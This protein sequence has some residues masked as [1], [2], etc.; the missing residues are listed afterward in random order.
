M[1]PIKPTDLHS[2]WGCLLIQA[3]GKLRPA[4]PGSV[5]ASHIST[6]QGYD[7]HCLSDSLEALPVIIVETNKSAWK[8]N[9]KH[10]FPTSFYPELEENTSERLKRIILPLFWKNKYVWSFTL[11]T[12]VLCGLK[13]VNTT[14]QSRGNQDIV[15]KSEKMFLINCQTNLSH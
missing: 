2:G 9:N 12:Q 15:Q 11:H 6:V 8:K 10:L 14:I 7:T 3:D 13:E 1:T 4:C 5:T